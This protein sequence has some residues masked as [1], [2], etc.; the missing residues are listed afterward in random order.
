MWR[1]L[2]VLVAAPAWA[3][4]ISGTFNASFLGFNEFGQPTT[5]YELL[6]S[7]SLQCPPS[8]PT[9][10]Y[11]AL[12]DCKY[13][14]APMESAGYISAF[15]GSNDNGVN[16][17]ESTSFPAGS[18]FRF[19]AK[20]ASCH[21]GNAI[22]EGGYIDITSPIVTI[23]P[24]VAINTAPS[25]PRAGSEL[26]LVVNGKPKGAETV[27]VQFTGAGIDTSVTL[28]PNDFQGTSSYGSAFARATPTAAGAMTVTAKLMPYGVSHSGM[29]MIQPASGGSGGGGG[30]GGSEG[31]GAGG[32]GDPVDEEPLGCAAAPGLL[33]PLALAVFRRR[34]PQRR[35]A[36]RCCG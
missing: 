2:V 10:H 32:G 1:L 11:R 24:Y 26:S 33:L 18:A 27:V 30:G 20:S 8:R 25:N 35:I 12:S 29:V 16:T 15:F 19:I 31:G 23:P 36:T 9:L 28:G 3:Q 34:R 5:R 17:A 14:E 4:A 13:V 21:C 6:L 7:C 22:G